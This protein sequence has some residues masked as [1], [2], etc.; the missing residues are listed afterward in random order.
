[1][2]HRSWTEVVDD[3]A[4]RHLVVAR[5]VPKAIEEPVAVLVAL[6]EGLAPL[7]DYALLTR[8]EEEGPVTLCAFSHPDD[9]ATLAAAVEAEEV[10]QYP[11]WASR[12][13]FT[14]DKAMAQG[15]VD[16]VEASAADP[17]PPQQPAATLLP[18]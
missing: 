11:E 4:A 16:A 7:G 1:M 13:A 6:I 14:L 10:E 12:R 15:I 3:P 18:A 2:T 5:I 8:C 9:A 17:A